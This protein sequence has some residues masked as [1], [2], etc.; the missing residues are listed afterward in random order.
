M[1]RYSLQKN[2]LGI[3]VYNLVMANLGNDIT[4]Q[5]RSK[6]KSTQG[7]C[8]QEVFGV[9]FVESSSVG[10]LISDTILYVSLVMILSIVFIRFLVSLIF[11]WFIGGN[12]GTMSKSFLEKVNAEKNLAYKAPNRV[13]DPLEIATMGRGFSFFLT[14]FRSTQTCCSNYS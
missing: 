9:A 1:S 4:L 6:D 3:D 10:C 8:L 11:A 2:F 5:M 7:S 14:Y 12:Y 13:L